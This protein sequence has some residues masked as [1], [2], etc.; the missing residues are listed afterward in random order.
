MTGAVAYAAYT[1]FHSTLPELLVTGIV[2]FQIVNNLTKLQQQLQT[3]VS[4]EGAYVRTIE[5]IKR[6][7]GQ[8]E[9][10]SGTATA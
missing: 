6:A 10:H 3:A 8:R 1:F 2:F 5:L 4:I 7:E 9:D